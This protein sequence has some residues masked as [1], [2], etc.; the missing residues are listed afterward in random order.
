MLVSGSQS[1]YGRISLI[2]VIPLKIDLLSV[3]SAVSVASKISSHWC[4]YMKAATWKVRLWCACVCVCAA[5]FHWQS[6]RRRLLWCCWS[7]ATRTP[8]AAAPASLS[9]H[10]RSERSSLHFTQ[11]VQPVQESQNQC[12]AESLRVETQP[13]D[14]WSASEEGGFDAVSVTFHCWFVSASDL[15]FYCQCFMNHFSR[16]RQQ[17]KQLAIKLSSNSQT[18]K[19]IHWNKLIIITFNNQVC[20]CCHI[21]CAVHSQ[22]RSWFAV[23][24]VGS[25]LNR[26]QN[27]IIILHSTQTK[28]K[29]QNGKWFPLLEFSLNV[30]TIKCSHQISARRLTARIIMRNYY[31]TMR[32][33]NIPA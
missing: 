26:E 31:S 14:F 10:T 25:Q 1:F 15:T 23:V 22:I 6:R 33:E 32:L 18:K 27:M 2:R 7:E 24:P 12:Q 30:R 5:H 19:Y 11:L 20:L 16:R 28:N 17:D 9:C 29:N 13:C 3:P 8:G 4:R 21:L